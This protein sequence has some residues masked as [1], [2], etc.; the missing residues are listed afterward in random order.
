MTICVAAPRSEF[1]RIEW[2]RKFLRWCLDL[3]FAALKKKEWPMV[4]LKEMT[5]ISLRIVFLCAKMEMN[6]FQEGCR[7][8]HTSR[9]AF[10][11]SAFG[12]N[13]AS[14][15]PAD[16]NGPFLTRK[17]GHLHLGN[18]SCHWAGIQSF[19]KKMRGFHPNNYSPRQLK[20]RHFVD[21]CPLENG[22]FPPSRLAV[23]RC[24]LP[25]QPSIPCG[26][27][28]TPVDR[29]TWKHGSRKRTL[30]EG[31]ISFSLSS[32]YVIVLFIIIYYI[33]YIYTY[34]HMII[35]D[36]H[37]IILVCFIWNF[38][39]CLVDCFFL[40]EATVV[41]AM[42]WT[43]THMDSTWTLEVEGNKLHVTADCPEPR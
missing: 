3:K 16:P 8:S 7:T 39:G 27:S 25:V 17:Y 10:A 22:L 4:H 19:I 5:Y 40:F 6:I 42:P 24:T 35:Y 15:D 13:I 41:S 29:T 31:K 32:L 37:M 38:V 33:Y 43:F 2:V 21:D 26:F 34:I 28:L 1:P 30:L 18:C 23:L 36:H 14:K 20:I 12:S 11:A 9:V